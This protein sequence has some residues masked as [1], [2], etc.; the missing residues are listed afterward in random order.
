M[1][2]LHD[3]VQN[4]YTSIFKRIISM[5]YFVYY[6]KLFLFLARIFV[7]KKIDTSQRI[8]KSFLDEIFYSLI[9]TYFFFCST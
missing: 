2:R 6:T 7:G 3:L 1:L 4:K 8:Q 9:L 5:L